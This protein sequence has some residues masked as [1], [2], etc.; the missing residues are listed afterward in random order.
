MME[1]VIDLH[2]HSKHARGCSPQ[3]GIEQMAKIAKIKGIDVVGTG[4]F[5]HPQ[6]IE[7]IKQ[8]TSTAENGLLVC[9]DTYF[10]PS[11]EINNTFESDDGKK[12]RVHT[13][14]VMLDIE[15]SEQFSDLITNHSKL[16]VDGRPWV[17]LDL[18]HTTELAFSITD[19]ALIIPAHI[20]TPWFSV[21]GAKAGF[22]SLKEAFADQTH[23]IYA[24]ETGL[25]SDPMMNWRC[26]WLDDVQLVSFSDAHSPAKLGREMT[27]LDIEKISYQDMFDAIK[28]KQVS[29][30]IEFFAQE[31][32]YFADGC[33]NCQLRTTPKETKDYGGRCPKCNKKITRG[34]LGRIDEL[35][36]REEGIKPNQASNYESLVPLQEMISMAIEKGI[37]TKST[38]RIYEWF[39]RQFSSEY[40][41]LHIREEDIKKQFINNP[42]DVDYNSLMKVSKALEQ[43]RD[44]KLDI[45]PGYDGVFGVVKPNFDIF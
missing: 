18:A 17:R 35:A 39:I 2:V 11:V 30:T 41:A 29:K 34:V 22:E 5:T 31:G 6:Y 45:Q 9:D 32:K 37:G 16:G 42:N 21:F 15:T 3:M 40:K 14:I 13:L 27:V 20:W 8:K 33:R 26:S 25:S 44:K 38:I 12:R 10:V 28:N 7:E 24:V 36:D 43:M 23:R 19:K 4:D 1:I